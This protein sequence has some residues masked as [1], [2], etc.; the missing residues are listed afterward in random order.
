MATTLFATLVLSACGGGG[1]STPSTTPPPKTGA[2]VSLTGLAAAGAPMV[3]TVSARDS[4]GT[5]FGPA[6]ISATGGYS[7]DVSAGVAPFILQATGTAGG[8][9]ATYYSSASTKPL[10]VNI[11]PFTEMIVAQAANASPA[12][13]FTS[14]VSA[15]S[16]T[17]PT[18]AAMTTAQA[19]V[20]GSLA[21]LL[22]QFGA[23]GAD[24]MAGTFVAGAVV[25]QSPI[26]VLLDSITVAPVAGVPSSFTLTANANTTL[27]ANTVLATLPPAATAT[28]LPINPALTPTIVSNINANVLP[29]VGALPAIQA[30]L[31]VFQGR[32]ATVLP[33]ANDAAL[34]ALFD[35]SFMDSGDN[36]AAFL[37]QITSNSIY[38]S[39]FPIGG[40]FSAPL[41]MA[42]PDGAFPNDATHQWFTSRVTTQGMGLYGVMRMLA[43]K[44][45]AG[46]WLLAGDQRQVG[47]NANYQAT[48]LVYPASGIA[49]IV[50][51]SAVPVN[52]A[53]A[54]NT[55]PAIFT[56]M[57]FGV[58][59]TPP[60]TAVSAVP[61][62]AVSGVPTVSPSDAVILAKGVSTVT[63]SGPGIIG[64]VAG[65]Q[66]AATIFTTLP[67]APAVAGSQWLQ[68]CLPLPT[69]GIAAVTTN[70]WD[71][72]LLTP[73][74]YTFTVT[75]TTPAVA[76]AV[77][78]PFSY[79]YRESSNAT[80][81][82]NLANFPVLNTPLNLGMFTSGAAIP[83]SWTIP[84]GQMQSSIGAYGY[85]I[86]S[87]T[88]TMLFN[89]WN[90]LGCTAVG[91]TP[92]TALGT[93]TLT[94]LT[95]PIFP[96]GS[97]AVN[98]AWV[99]NSTMDATGNAFYYTAY[100]Y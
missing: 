2:A 100:Q 13:I 77:G 47:V 83:M 75:G 87:P 98:Q 24:L 34:V 25:G 55:P 16:C 62:V 54:P 39:P 37:A 48:Q 82:V 3:G 32:F 36:S 67:T 50:N 79:V 46:T 4:R 85:D 93:I 99:N 28:P 70:C 10:V 74:V 19:N 57:S 86:L 56:Y 1:S 51:A 22:T 58:F 7:L 29:A 38:S 5:T 12:A 69:V 84:A 21:N 81:V 71:Q 26:D 66:G 45:A 94:S 91:G 30:Q 33:A 63:V 73:G 41:S 42:S 18:A 40:T 9:T 65:V 59:A 76:P 35:A 49:A 89:A 64:A 20:Q 92:G 11:T 6:T 78:T 90:C 31:A 53:V 88:F 72:T 95:L 80:S 97:G 8:K 27:P 60:V 15:A 14:C 17:L 61:A 68:Q 52:V 23:T 44:N 96:V 43:I